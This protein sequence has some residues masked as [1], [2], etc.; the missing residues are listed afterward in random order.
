MIATLTPFFFYQNGAS[1][2]GLVEIIRSD[3]EKKTSAS[4]I[5]IH[6]QRSKNR[7]LL[8]QAHGPLLFRQFKQNNI[9]LQ[10]Y[11]LTCLN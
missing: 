1:K 10:D 6:R 7:G 5:C 8:L 3:N 11:P 2:S 4:D 9:D